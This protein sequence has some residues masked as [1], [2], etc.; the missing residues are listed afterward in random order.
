M[1]VNPTNPLHWDRG[2][3]RPP[4]LRNSKRRLKLSHFAGRRTLDAAWR[5]ERDELYGITYRP[6]P[7]V[8][9][10]SSIATSNLTSSTVNTMVN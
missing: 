3:P 8:N 2:R 6:L 7:C 5:A 10:S 1:L 4:Y 9:I